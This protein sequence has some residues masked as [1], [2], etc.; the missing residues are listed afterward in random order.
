MALYEVEKRFL[1]DMLNRGH[2]RYI[3][4]YQMKTHFIGPHSFVDIS[5]E[6]LARQ[7]I[8][9]PLYWYNDT[10]DIVFNNYLCSCGKLFIFPSSVQMSGIDLDSRQGICPCDACRFWVEGAGC[11]VPDTSFD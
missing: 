2:V 4:P 7:H 11:V 9:C 3:T 8:K 10:V 5:R 1:I 6:H